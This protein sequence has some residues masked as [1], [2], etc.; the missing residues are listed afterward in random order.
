M[1]NRGGTLD[2]SVQQLKR[3]Q[4]STNGQRCGQHAAIGKCQQV[5]ATK[6]L[7]LEIRPKEEAGAGHVGKDQ[8]WPRGNT[9]EGLE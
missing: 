4:S 6:T 8:G 1:R 9:L 2:N 3:R 5:L 7:V